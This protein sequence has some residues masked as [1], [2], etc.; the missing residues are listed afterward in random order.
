MNMPPYCKFEVKLFIHAV[1]KGVL[2][3]EPVQKIVIF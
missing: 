1:G 3:A 2:K